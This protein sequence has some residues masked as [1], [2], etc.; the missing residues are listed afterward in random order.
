MTQTPPPP[1][2]DAGAPPLRFLPQPIELRGVRGDESYILVAA[3]PA[4]GVLECGTHFTPPGGRGVRTDTYG[5]VGY[6]TSPHYDSLL[7]KLIVHTPGD[8][9]KALSRTARALDHFH[10]EGVPHNKALLAVLLGDDAVQAGAIDTGYIDHN[11]GR[12][13]AA[14]ADDLLASG[15][16]AA[17]AQRVEAAGPKGSAPVAAPMQGTIVSLSVAAG[18]LVQAGQELLIM[19]AM[20]MEHVI[21]AP[22]TGYV[23]SFLVADGDGARLGDT[24]CAEWTPPSS[25]VFSRT[26]LV[27]STAAVLFTVGVVVSS[28]SCCDGGDAP[29]RDRGEADRVDVAVS[30]NVAVP[31]RP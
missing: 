23:E 14:Q 31:S 11:V 28:W 8:I 22:G 17:T 3:D 18:E 27:S 21:E 12:L 15:D 2:G 7:A 13:V 16:N 20:K 5:Y 19:D 10:I 25:S 1:P 4:T 29:T 26:P 24:D 6:T 30:R 9:T